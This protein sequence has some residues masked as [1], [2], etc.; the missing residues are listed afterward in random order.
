MG[1]S[2]PDI[3][4]PHQALKQQAGGL[5]LSPQALAAV[6]KPAAAIHC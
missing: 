1:K 3:E 6:N 5:A 4:A 2:C